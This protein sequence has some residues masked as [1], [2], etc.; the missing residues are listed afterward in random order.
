MG[1]AYQHASNLSTWTGY[2]WRDRT[3]SN[4]VIAEK[5][6]GLGIPATDAGVDLPSPDCVSTEVAPVEVLLLVA[7][8]FSSETAAY[9]NFLR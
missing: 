6:K 2:Q 3:L 7:S 4:P 5:S 9:V 1:T 8:D